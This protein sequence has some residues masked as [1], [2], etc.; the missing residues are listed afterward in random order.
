V[1]KIIPA[2]YGAHFAEG[3]FQQTPEQL[4]PDRNYF[5]KKDS[6]IKV[7]PTRETGGS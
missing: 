7:A 3:L 4:L 5:N 2:K 1:L 6:Y